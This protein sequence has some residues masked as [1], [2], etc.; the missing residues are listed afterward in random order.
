MIDRGG[1]VRALRVQDLASWVVIERDQE[2]ALVDESGERR[3]EQRTRWQL[4]VHADTP[5]GRGTAH[6]TVDGIEGDPVELVEEAAALARLS[7][8]RAWA[9]APPAAPARV[10]LEDPALATGAALDVVAA[11]AKRIPRRPGATL[12]ARVALER[13]RVAVQAHQGVHTE[14]AATRVRVDALVGVGGHALAI[15]REARRSDALDLVAAV[16]EA[17][18]DLRLLAAAGAP[19][20]GPCAL[21]LAPDALLHGGLGVWEAFVTQADPAISREGLTRY[22]GRAPIAAGADQVAEPLSITS[23]GALAFGVRSAPLGD[24]GGAVRRFPLVARGLAA[25]LGLSPREAGLRHRDPNGGVRNLVVSAGTW[26]ERTLPASTRVIEVRRLRG[27]AIDPYTGDGELELG[28]AL[29]R[30]TGAPFAGGTVF[31]DVIAALARARRSA[32]RIERGPYVG[33]ASILVES[34]TL[35]A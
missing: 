27:L 1:L 4:T 11:I 19:V 6:V 15:A 13:E 26:D 29:D 17:I 7:V 12:D 18:R 23:D 28:L 20:P 14:W 21:V 5:E 24:A 8:G 16:D 2:L 35:M 32:R 33:P 10:D 34:A 25:G 30:A 22:H 9:T 31:L 3:H